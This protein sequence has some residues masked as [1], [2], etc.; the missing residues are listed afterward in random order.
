MTHHWQQDFHEYVKVFFHQN[1]FRSQV[2]RFIRICNHSIKL[3]FASERHKNKYFP[4]L[5]HLEIDKVED[6]FCIYIFDLASLNMGRSLINFYQEFIMKPSFPSK[7]TATNG[8][9]CFDE[10]IYYL[11]DEYQ[12][13]LWVVND[14][15]AVEFGALANPFR[16]FFYDWLARKNIQVT[17]VAAVAD[18]NSA[19]LLTGGSG[20]GKSTTTVSCLLGGL[21]FLGDD[22]CILKYE[23]EPMVYAL[24]NTFKI[25]KQLFNNAYFSALKGKEEGYTLKENIEKAIFHSNKIASFNLATAKPVKAIL[26]LNSKKSIHPRIVASTAKDLNSH[27]IFNTMRQTV[28]VSKHLAEYVTKNIQEFI[29]FIP[30]YQMDLSSN[31][32]K[33]VSLIAEF[34]KS[35]I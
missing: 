33:N 27:L 4:A 30:C 25:D 22:Q 7:R 35:K 31:Y 9:F 8:P 11:N 18:N 20:V 15:D 6:A 29:R 34:L 17:H 16:L 21:H 28:G 14:L 23:N 1:F 19:V 5:K 2:I 32:Q 10:L 12:F 13:S 24:Y 3:C 26:K